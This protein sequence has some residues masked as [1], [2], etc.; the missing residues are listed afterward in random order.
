MVGAAASWVVALAQ[1]KGPVLWAAPW[2]PTWDPDRA[3]VAAVAANWEHNSA[4]EPV[5]PV[6]PALR[7]AAQEVVPVAAVAAVAA[8]RWAHCQT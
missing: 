1:A 3:P 7:A 4:V 2:S 6:E 8:A 5:E